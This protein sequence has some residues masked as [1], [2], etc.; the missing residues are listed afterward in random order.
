MAA[1]TT[2]PA[3]QEEAAAETP[4]T[5]EMEEQ[6]AYEY[7][8]YLFKADKTGTDKLRRL[9]RGLQAGMVRGQMQQRIVYA[10]D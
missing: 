3:A 7:W 9:L 4:G 10:E 5:R 8:G 6:E 2:A 1:T